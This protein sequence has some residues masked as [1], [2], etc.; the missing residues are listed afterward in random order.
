[1]WALFRFQRWCFWHWF[2]EVTWWPGLSATNGFERV[3]LGDFLQKGQIYLVL[4]CNVLWFKRERPYFQGLLSYRFILQVVRFGEKGNWELV[5]GLNAVTLLIRWRNCVFLLCL[6]F[7]F[8]TR[9]LLKCS[10]V[11]L[12]LCVLQLA[13]DA[14]RAQSSFFSFIWMS[15]PHLL[16]NMNFVLVCSAQIPCR[17]L[18]GKWLARVQKS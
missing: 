8:Y 4:F 9:I 5:I 2:I 18:L 14:R 10:F 1:M 12:I 13:C 3:V 11:F 15:A 17:L 16:W 7:H 6:L